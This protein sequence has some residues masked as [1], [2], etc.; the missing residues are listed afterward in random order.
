MWVPEKYECTHG[1]TEDNSACS[2]NPLI[3]CWVSRPWEKTIFMLYMTA[4]TIISIILCLAEFVYVITRTT[5][6]GVHRRA[7]KA[8]S[9]KAYEKS[10]IDPGM[11]K[12]LLKHLFFL[13]LIADFYLFVWNLTIKNYQIEK[14]ISNGEIDL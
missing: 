9:T 13:Q 8:I 1:D 7:E 2:Q 5:K 14:M 11:V 4:V 6:K 3:P 10:M 12:K